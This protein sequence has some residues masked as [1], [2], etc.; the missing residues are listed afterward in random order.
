MRS[1]LVL[2]VLDREI[3]GEKEVM[4]FG[5]ALRDMG[6][7]SGFPLMMNVVGDPLAPES[8]LPSSARRGLLVLQMTVETATEAMTMAGDIVRA[9]RAEPARIIAM[10]AVEIV[11]AARTIEPPV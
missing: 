5:G 1:F 10:R 9:G 11:R 7:L 8:E 2:A 3:R 4:R 6:Q